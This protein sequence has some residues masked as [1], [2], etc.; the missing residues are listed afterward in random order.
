MAYVN[1]RVLKSLKEDLAWAIDKR[2]RIVS[3]KML[4]KT[5]SYTTKKLKNKAV[6]NLKQFCIRYY[7]TLS[8]VF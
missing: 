7:V 2:L 8:N 3:N 1:I 6:L 4:F 5:V